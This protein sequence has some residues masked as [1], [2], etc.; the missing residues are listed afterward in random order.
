M[1]CQDSIDMSNDMHVIN[2]CH[3]I[4]IEVNR[5]HVYVVFVANV[6]GNSVFVRCRKVLGREP[7][8]RRKMGEPNGVILSSEGRYSWFM[9]FFLVCAQECETLCSKSWRSLDKLKKFEISRT[10]VPLLNISRCCHRGL[11]SLAVQHLVLAC[12]Q[13]VRMFYTIHAFP[14]PKEKPNTRT[15]QRIRNDKEKKIL[16]FSLREPTHSHWSL[17]MTIDEPRC[18]TMELWVPW[19]PAN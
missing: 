8:T 7:M 5:C 1:H 19:F 2:W 13:G 17:S 15:R 12:L 14:P 3:L 6:E 18:A 9:L 4:S 10:A 16:I 11:V